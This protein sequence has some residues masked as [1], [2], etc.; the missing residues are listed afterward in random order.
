MTEEFPLDR[1]DEERYLIGLL[2]PVTLR[3]LRDDALRRVDPAS[4]GNA[5]LAGLWAAAQRLRAREEQINRRSLLAEVRTV[6]HGAAYPQ[7]L[8]G[9]DGYVP[10][11]YEYPTVVTEVIAAGKLRR[12]VETLDRA[13]QRAYSAEDADTSVAVAVEELTRLAEVTE[14]SGGLVHIGT[15]LAKLDQDYRNGPD[16]AEQ[17]IPSPW[18]E[19]DEITAGGL[20]RG[21]LVVIGAR[22]GDGKSVGA[23]QIAV[24]AANQDYSAV[25]FSLEMSTDEVGGRIAANDAE[26]E[27]GEI[28]AK[29]LTEDSLRKHAKLVSRAPQ[30]PLWVCDRANLTVDLIASMARAHKRRHGLDVLAVDYLQLMSL[31]GV[32]NREQVV[33][34][35]ARR[36]KNLAREL[37]CAVVL[38]SQL[39]RESVKRGGE[40]SLADLRESGG[41]EAHADL[42]VL[43]HRPRHPADH[44]YAGKPTGQIVLG[45][46][47]NRF[48]PCK[49]ITL[50]WRGHFAK[51]GR[52][53]R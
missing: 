32:Q 13:R 20:H 39:N 18:P 3:T 48:G 51:I 52:D 9:L 27:M 2:L 16:L 43:L 41:I 53:Q 4:F 23:H 50:D 45:V 30:L 15:V 1:P 38:P 14:E 25:V 22:P 34:E 33:S 7:L 35:I 47:K 5:H 37:D 19:F 10:V 31:K 46:E 42:V 6:V 29:R 28:A 24:H 21:R 12:V 49:K 40:P 11:T 26:I 44:P 36:F 8:D 17:P